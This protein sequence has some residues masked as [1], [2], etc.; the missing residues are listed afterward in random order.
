MRKNLVWFHI[1][2]LSIILA[3]C[4]E[5]RSANVGILITPSPIPD[6]QVGTKIVLGSEIPT[7]HNST[8]FVEKTLTPD[9]TKVTQTSLSAVTAIVTEDNRSPITGT[10]VDEQDMHKLGIMVW[11]QLTKKTALYGFY[12]PEIEMQIEMKRLKVPSGS[13]SSGPNQS[14]TLSFSPYTRKIAYFTKDKGTELWI[15]DL[16]LTNIKR[17]WKDDQ[18]WLGDI[19]GKND[20]L[21]TWGINDRYLVVSS[22]IKENHLLVY[23]L[24]ADENLKLEGNCNRIIRSPF[25]GQFVIGCT[26]IQQGNQE[27]KILDTNGVIDLSSSISPLISGILDWSYSKDANRILFITEDEK[28]GI[29]N[30]DKK[31]SYMPLTFDMDSWLSLTW[32]KNLQWSQDGEHVLVYGLESAPKLCPTQ[33][34]TGLQNKNS[35]RSCWFILD[36]YSGEILWWPKENIQSVVDIPWEYLRNEYDATLSPDGEWISSTFTDSRMGHAYYLLS[37]S[38]LSDEVRVITLEQAQTIFWP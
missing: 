13:T 11:N 34:N 12:D 29:I 18:Y 5:V 21:I 10:P 23:D 22:V 24:I 6:S 27:L 1:F 37:I 32:R 14:V 2:L 25:S 30:T 4:S 9:D 16:E 38:L 19:T 33:K 36:S 8:L 3:A 15:S 35:Q 31:I 28:I 20:V 7:E 17:A 26:T